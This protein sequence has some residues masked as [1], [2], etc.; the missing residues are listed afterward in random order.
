MKVAVLLVALVVGVA[1]ANPINDLKM[2]GS[3]TFNWMFWKIY[4]ISLLTDNGS[5]EQ[6]QNPLAIEITYAR[7]IEGE[8]LVQSTIDEWQR[9]DILWQETWVEQLAGIFPDIVEGDQII[10]LVDRTNKSQFYHNN[11][12][13][14][15]IEDPEFTTSFLSIW[16]SPNSRSPRLTE[17]LTGTSG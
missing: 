13:I 6:G 9:Q 8:Q 17:E 7:D 5:Y 1:Q 3:T 11:L 10:L 12:P 2:V 4:D 15:S 16:L 14:G